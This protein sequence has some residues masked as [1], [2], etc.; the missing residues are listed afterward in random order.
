MINYFQKIISYDKTDIEDHLKKMNLYHIF[1]PIFTE[2]K[3]RSIDV[4]KFIVYAFTYG[5]P[6]IGILNDRKKEKEAILHYLGLEKDIYEN[7]LIYLKNTIVVG[8]I[9]KWLKY[10]DNRQ[11]E[12]LMILQESYVQHQRAAISNIKK[13]DSENTDFDQKFKCVEY[14]EKLKKMIKDA[15]SELQQNDPLFKE[16]Y[17]EVYKAK[18]K[19]SFGLETVLREE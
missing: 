8:V 12:Y 11:I 13:G 4:I 1:S 16:V 6:K 10:G 9:E 18:H 15:E 19:K 3:E 17:S 5:S 7:D 2:Y 14:M